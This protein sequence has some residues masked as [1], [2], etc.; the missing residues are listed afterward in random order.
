MREA[1][2]GDSHSKIHTDAN[3]DY[4]SGRKDIQEQALR[5]ELNDT[6]DLDRSVT[7]RAQLAMLLRGQKQ[8]DAS[9]R[10]LSLASSDLPRVSS[11]SKALVE[12]AEG[13]LL[14]EQGQLLAAVEKLKLGLKHLEHSRDHLMLRQYVS[15]KWKCAELEASLGHSSIADAGLSRARSVAQE[16]GDLH[17]YS[18][19]R[20]VEAYVALSRDDF[21][22]AVAALMWV[23]HP[24]EAIGRTQPR[25]HFIAGE[26]AR[27]WAVVE[28]THRVRKQ[29][30]LGCVHPLWALK[31]AAQRLRE[32]M[33][34]VMR[35]PFLGSLAIA[36][37]DEIYT[38]L[39]QESDMIPEGKGTRPRFTQ[40][41]RQQI[42]AIYTGL[43]ALCGQQ[44]IEGDD[45]HV[46]HIVLHSMGHAPKSTARSAYLNY[47][48]VH[49]KCNLMRSDN[50]F[51]LIK[52]VFDNNPTLWVERAWRG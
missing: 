11:D 8:W 31:F 45:W 10:E 12:A 17:G 35:V 32:S 44:I 42:F 37:P 3:T 28:W 20:I 25:P 5:A 19:T 21:K 24:P 14:L 49:A 38:S 39:L 4:Y 22:S 26:L 40:T 2:V 1:T 7:L 29:R 27:A 13:A 47:R 16:I 30:W 36:S 52:K 34:F 46:D 48:P 6:D 33:S 9:R 43:C 23:S 18:N 50:D 51:W 15:S 41:E